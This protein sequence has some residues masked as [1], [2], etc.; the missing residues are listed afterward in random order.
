MEVMVVLMLVMV[1]ME[2]MV[3]MAEIGVKLVLTE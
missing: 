2:E 3:V 1:V